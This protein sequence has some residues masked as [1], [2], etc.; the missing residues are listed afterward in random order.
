MNPVSG[1]E[2]TE[3][4]AQKRAILASQV[5]E[6]REIKGITGPRYA[7]VVVE[8]INIFRQKIK[9]N[10]WDEL[11]SNDDVF[12]LGNITEEILDDLEKDDNVKCFIE[13]ST[14]PKSWLAEIEKKRSE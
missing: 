7:R 14:L 5:K 3:S 11:L 12:I 8:D 1:L 13:I 4:K 2:G 9:N 10:S 6:E